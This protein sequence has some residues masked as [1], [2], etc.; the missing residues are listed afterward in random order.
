MIDNRIELTFDNTLSSLAGYDYGVSIYQEQ[1]KGKI[2]L[3]GQFEIVFPAQIKS[4]ASSFVQ[5]FFEEIVSTIGL[6]NT[7]KN[8]IIVSEKE[9]FSDMIMSKLQ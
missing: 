4:V 8:S 5:G 3:K 1:V 6:M 7:E 2:D 9:G